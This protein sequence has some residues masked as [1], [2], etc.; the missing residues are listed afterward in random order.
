MAFVLQRHIPD[1]DI[2]SINHNH[3]DY[4]N[5][6]TIEYLHNNNKIK[7]CDFSLLINKWQKNVLEISKRK[8]KRGLMAIDS[9]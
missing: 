4:W 6:N 1:I 2:I 5:N 9:N 7:Y 3:Y 8:V